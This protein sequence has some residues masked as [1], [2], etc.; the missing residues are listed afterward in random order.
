MHKIV[1]VFDFMVLRSIRC[2]KQRKNSS[3]MVTK[4][5]RTFQNGI[6]QFVQTVLR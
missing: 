3:Y 1:V 5:L 2:K 6:L 4:I